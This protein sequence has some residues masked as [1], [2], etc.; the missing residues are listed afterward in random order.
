MAEKAPDKPA[1]QPKGQES[2]TTVRTHPL[3]GY[4]LEGE[5]HPTITPE[6]VELTA[7]ELEAAER[8]AAAAQIV[9]FYDE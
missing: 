5:G 9:L 4:R 6:G 1:E 2:R 7:K 8:S 3:H